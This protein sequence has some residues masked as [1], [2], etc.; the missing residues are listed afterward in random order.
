M[1]LCIR[2]AHGFGMNKTGPPAEGWI[3]RLYE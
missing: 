1:H 3:E 2:G